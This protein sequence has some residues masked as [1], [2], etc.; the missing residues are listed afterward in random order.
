MATA[1]S[2]RWDV[3]RVVPLLVV[4]GAVA[5]G[6]VEL[7]SELHL[8][9]YTNDSSMH[10]EMVRFA[11]SQLRAGHLP[12]R[13]W[14]PYLNLGSPDFLHYQSLGATL[15][16]AAGLL[17][18]P[19]HAFVWSLYLLLATWPVSIYASARCFGL[20]RMAAAGAAACA[21]F[22]VSR[23]G[24]GY[25]TTSYLAIGF[26]LWSQLVAMWTLPLAWGTTWQAVHRGRFWRL[27]PVLVALTVAC[28]F[29]TG[30]LAIGVIVLWPFLARDGFVGRLRRAGQTLLLSGFL[31][32]WVIVPLV[33]L[34]PY[35]SIDEFLAHGPDVSSYGARSAL[36]WLVD[37]QL[38]DAHRLPV[39]TALGGLGLLAALLGRLRDAGHRAILAA[40]VGSLVLFFGKPTLG[41]LIVLVPGHAD[42]FMRRFLMGVQLAAILFAGVGVGAL[43]RAGAHGLRALSA[44]G[45]ARL[46]HPT[47][48]GALGVAA[49][50]ALLSPAWQQA[51]AVDTGGGG[52]L[53]E[54]NAAWIAAQ[55]KADATAGHQ[56]DALVALARSHGP[57]RIYAGMPSN[58]GIDFEVGGVPVFR[59]L[60]SLD[61]EEVGFTN[62]T[63]SLMSDPEAY[64]DQYVPGDY[65]LFG[66]RYLL[67]PSSMAPPV[68]ARRLATRGSY[69]LWTVGDTTLVGVVDTVGPPVVATRRDLGAANARFLESPLST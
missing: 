17:V 48:A 1:A 32:A 25:E 31:A 37:G 34:K 11:A 30:Y 6:L 60:A 13:S 44:H 3:A 63:A 5:F 47:V 50:V 15:T 21:P 10:E 2:P 66:I 65:T 57:G 51:M 26:G 64:F 55:A 29:M 54:S 7:R 19:N 27:A 69:A 4:A 12:M 16:G 33:V 43:A 28:H 39:L 56:V 9:A 42:L 24:I 22:V 45:Q 52:T 53:P 40:L 41:P 62:R 20:D 49:L 36:R 8:V 23:L 61:V 67:L 18:G 35:A 14:F 58:W 68:P 38:L 59:Y 46:A